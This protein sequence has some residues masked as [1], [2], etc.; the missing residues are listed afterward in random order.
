M[1]LRI[2]NNIVLASASPSRK[3]LLEKAGI[4]FFMDEKPGSDQSQEA[5][6]LRACMDMICRGYR[7]EDVS[8]YIK[9]P[10]IKAACKG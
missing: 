3:M 6:L 2:R 1:V 9:N 7:Y 4:P 5:A 8:R 10:L